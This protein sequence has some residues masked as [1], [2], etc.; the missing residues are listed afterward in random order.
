[1]R[2]LRVSSILTALLIACPGAEVEERD[3]SFP[4]AQAGA[5]AARQDAAPA[6]TAIGTDAVPG[7]RALADA[8]DLDAEPAE[9]GA[10]DAG[11]ADSGDCTGVPMPSCSGVCARTAPTC[12]NNAWSCSGPGYEA[13]EASC[14]G[15][16]NDCDGET[17]EGV[18]TACAVPLTR[19][20]ANLNAIWDLDFAYDCRAYLT[21]LISGPDF[22][23]VVSATA[24]EPVATYF[25]NANQNMG[26]ALADPDPTQERVVV[27]YSCCPNCGCQAKNGLTLLYTCGPQDP[28]C[29]CAAQANCPGFLDAPFLEAGLLN[30]SVQFN[31]I[32][33]STPN[34]L[35]VGPGG[36]YY[37]GNF[38]PE[39]CSATVAC[40]ACDPDHPGV[41]CRPSRANCCDTTP[42]GRLA[43]FTLPAPGV[44]PTWRV[45]AIFEGEEIL[46][47]SSARDGTVLVGTKDAAIGGRLHRY[48]PTTHTS[49]VIADYPGT[50]FSITED[51]H[52]GDIY[53]EV[54]ASPKIRRLSERGAPLPL[55]ATVPADPPSEGVLTY[56]PDQ[57]LY[58]LIGNS[59]AAAGLDRYPLR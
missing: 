40:D 15:F 27:T 5:D 36:A 1:M 51:R 16:D 53:L 22:T 8:S 32:P 23:R 44:E 18:C 25:G 34:G 28:G 7:D 43:A 17:D 31:G 45:V 3:S 42:L 52:T 19:I 38:M 48:D 37:V 49:T 11:V 57:A 30:T 59:N 4:D 55:P 35:A 2:I 9:G 58:R 24:S 6:D 33:V 14:D 39:T 20:A 46:G 13:I 21:S 56:G 47:L 50:V 12:A 54:R 29:G 41:V 10:S 26:F